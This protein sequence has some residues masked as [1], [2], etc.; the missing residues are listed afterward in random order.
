[1]DAAAHVDLLLQALALVHTEEPGLR[2]GEEEREEGG[3]G[4]GREGRGGGEGRCWTTDLILTSA[5]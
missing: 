4:G 3:E 5:A 2:G 1:M